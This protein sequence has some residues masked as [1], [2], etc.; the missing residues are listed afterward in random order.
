MGR[1]G[2]KSAA[3]LCWHRAH[4]AAERLAALPGFSV[5]PGLFFKEFVLKT[6]ID[7]EA[8]A[9]KLYARKIVCGLPLSR[10]WP[11]RRKEL[12]VCVTEKNTRADIDDLTEALREET[13]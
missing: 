12:L 11:G 8:L 3:E 10:Y 13:L 1:S 5:A 7:A 4:Y 6:P 2:M 9:E